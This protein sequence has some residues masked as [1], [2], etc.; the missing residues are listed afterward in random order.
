[1]KKNDGELSMPKILIVEDDAELAR[2]VKEIL[3]QSGHDVTV[4]GSRATGM[5]ELAKEPDVALVDVGLPDGSGLDIVRMAGT[6]TI[7]STMILMSGDPRDEVVVQGL[8]DGAVD[9][10]SKPFSMPV[11]QARVDNALRSRSSSTRA[12][13]RIGAYRFSSSDQMLRTDAGKSIALTRRE[14]DILKKL[15]QTKGPVDRRTLLRE[16]WGYSDRVSTHTVETHIY[17]L[18]QKIESDPSSPA[19]IVTVDGGYALA[20]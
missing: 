15:L 9:F 1:M 4:A 18:R 13:H 11:L 14:S 10:L 12:M 8:E 20:S 19:L 3:V 6:G 16:V 5:L 7:T 17:R 2:T